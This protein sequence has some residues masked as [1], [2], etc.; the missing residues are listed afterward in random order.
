MTS[1]QRQA[2]PLL[3]YEEW[4]IQFR[5]DCENEG[6]LLAFDALGETALKLLWGNGLA[7]MYE[8]LLEASMIRLS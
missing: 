5:K 7:R 8:P 1:D 6:K 3:T 2:A 4:R